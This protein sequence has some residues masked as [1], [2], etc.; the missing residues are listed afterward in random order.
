MRVK[1]GQAPFRKPSYFL[2]EDAKKIH[3]FTPA[4]AG[5]RYRFLIKDSFRREEYIGNGW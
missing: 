2:Q 3:Q 5:G 1:S 4:G